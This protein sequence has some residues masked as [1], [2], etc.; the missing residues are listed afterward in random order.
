MAPRD[1]LREPLDHLVQLEHEPALA[2]SRNADDRDELRRALREHAGER[3]LEQGDLAT[4]ADEGRAVHPL[5]RD[6]RARL[7]RLPRPYRL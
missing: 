4:S 2:D 5:D 3:I 6:P 1:E 7:N